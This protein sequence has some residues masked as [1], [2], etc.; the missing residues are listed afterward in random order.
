MATQSDME[1]ELYNRQPGVTPQPAAPMDW[2]AA[3]RQSYHYQTIPEAYKN[4]P[5]FGDVAN[6]PNQDPGAFAQNYLSQQRAKGLTDAGDAAALSGQ[7]AIGGV[8][9]KN[10]TATQQWN[11]M[12]SAPNVTPS[13]A[14]S[15]RDALF[16][17]L[18]AR[19]QQGTNVSRTDPNIR[20]QVDPYVAQQTRASRDYLSAVAEKQGPLGNIEGERA[21]AAER[22]GQNAGLFEAEIIGRELS[23]KREEI[24]QALQMALAMG[25]TSAALELQEKLGLLNNNIQQQQ[26]GLGQQGLNLQSRG[27]DDAMEQFMRELALREWQLGDQSDLSWAQLGG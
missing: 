13:A 25:N 16:Q 21:M 22:L 23:A 20:Q 1:N 8:L 11:A 9:P 7:G 18:M 24:S 6:D 14:T 19:A 2:K 17:Q 4:I 10:A 5:G 12:P 27:Q 26:V 3:G 15:G